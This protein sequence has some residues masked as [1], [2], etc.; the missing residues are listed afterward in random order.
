MKKIM[1]MAAVAFAACSLHAAS[2]TW[3]VVVS[4]F[5][6][7][8]NPASGTLILAAGEGS[9]S[10]AFDETGT[11]SGLITADTTDAF[12]ANTA[13]SATM[14]TELFDMEGN[15]KGMYSKV[16]NFTMPTLPGDAPSQ[17][18][19]FEVLNGEIGL[20]FGDAELGTLPYYENAAAQGWTAA[21]PE[22]TSGL[23]LLL[24]MAGLALHRK[25]A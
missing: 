15:S 9:W 14:T 8:W 12:A 11:A 22:P 5:A 19:T 23:L 3:N 18:S 20:A 1:M 24:C 7:N 17:A 21:V 2:A 13:W 4:Q 16:F 25:Q 6:S 10:F